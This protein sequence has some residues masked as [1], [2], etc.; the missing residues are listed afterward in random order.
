MAR[1]NYYEILQ[2]SP[3]AEEEVIQAAF[4]GLAKKY[5]PDRNKDPSAHKKMS[6][7]N[8]A[9]EVLSDPVRRQAYD[10]ELAREQPKQPA[11]STASSQV[12]EV[13]FK[14]PGCSMSSEARISAPNEIVTCTRCGKQVRMVRPGT[15]VPPARPVCDRPIEDQF[16][17]AK[18]K[19]LRQLH[20]TN[21]S[22][23]DGYFYAGLPILGSVLLGSV[24][25]LVCSGTLANPTSVWRSGIGMCLLILFGLAWIGAAGSLVYLRQTLNLRHQERIQRVVLRYALARHHQKVFDSLFEAFRDLADRELKQAAGHYH[26][27]RFGRRVEIYRALP[28]WVDC[29]ITAY[30]LVVDCE[31]YYFLPDCVLIRRLETFHFLRY[32]ELSLDIRHLEVYCG[33][34][35]CGYKWIHQRVDGGPDRRFRFNCQIPIYE[36]QF[37]TWPAL[38]FS[39]DGDEILLIADSSKILGRFREAVSD[40]RRISSTSPY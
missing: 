22:P 13:V 26:G 2:V 24:M 32:D 14:C 6:L 12:M 9:Y 20:A 36:P 30:C 25:L 40:W 39:Y 1:P 18:L 4:R 16:N 10:L 11:G 5:H 19:Q 37:E 15:R 38:A 31:T 33:D 34:R 17:T 27:W 35:V 29:N 7:L 3:L 8:E 21:H 28:K 23:G